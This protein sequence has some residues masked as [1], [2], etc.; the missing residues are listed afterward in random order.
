MLNNELLIKE[1]AGKYGRERSALLPVLHGVAERNNY[2]T[3]DDLTLIAKELDLSGAQVFGTASF[4]SF[5]DLKPRGKY[6]IRLCKTISCDMKNKDEIVNQI[7]N[8]LKIKVG[9]TTDDQKFTFLFTNCMGWCDKS[10]SMLINETPYS[11]LTP[12][13][14]NTILKEYQQRD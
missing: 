8:T 14:V 2:L 13:K 10:P 3:E 12:D 9:E 5:F 7:E 1:L 4:Y 11:G 6:V